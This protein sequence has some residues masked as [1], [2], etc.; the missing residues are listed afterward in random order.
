M[1]P[2]LLETI[3]VTDS[4]LVPKIVGRPNDGG[5]DIS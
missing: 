4:G 2:L 1:V 5:R 3:D